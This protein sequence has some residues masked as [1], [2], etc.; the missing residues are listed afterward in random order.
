MCF[1]LGFISFLYPQFTVVRTSS[2]Y[3]NMHLLGAGSFVDVVLTFCLL[4]VL[5]V[6]ILLQLRGQEPKLSFVKVI[7]RWFFGNV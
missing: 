3:V 7:I 5:N 6:P 4:V 1:T 2:Q